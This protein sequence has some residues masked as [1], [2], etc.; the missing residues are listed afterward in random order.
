[1]N[2]GPESNNKRPSLWTVLKVVWTESAKGWAF[3]GIIVTGASVVSLI[4][5]WFG[6]QLADYPDTVLG[7][8]RSIADQLQLVLFDWWTVHIWD[9]W[10]LPKWAFDVL[11]FWS[12]SGRANDRARV[13]FIHSM[14][15]IPDVKE[16]Y[17][18]EKD[19]IDQ[20]R[21]WAR[22]KAYA[23]GPFG[24]ATWLR[25]TA[26]MLIPVSRFTWSVWRRSDKTLLAG[27][28]QM[29][30]SIILMFVSLIAPFLFTSAFFIWNF[31]EL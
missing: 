1:M 7:Y 10:T 27:T 5:R 15:A 23:F 31:F 28:R 8:Y 18:R 3:L 17:E 16:T 12:L 9:D 25:K 21:Q 20:R 30:F 26:K 6:I 2:N 11:V 29:R 14:H 24:Y 19:E 13:I 4:Q 22:I